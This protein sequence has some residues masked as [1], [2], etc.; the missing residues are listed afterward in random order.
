MKTFGSFQELATGITGKPKK[1]PKVLE[2]SLPE[3]IQNLIDNGT[4]IITGSG[5]FVTAS[6]EHPKRN[7]G[8]IAE[9]DKISRYINKHG[10]EQENWT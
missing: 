6:Q 2:Q 3:N 1:R 9:I 4:I 10:E 7:L 8:N 5:D